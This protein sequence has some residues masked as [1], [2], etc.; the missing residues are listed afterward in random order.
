MG[1]VLRTVLVA[2]LV[3][4]VACSSGGG[5]KSMASRTASNS[6]AGS[7]SRDTSAVRLRPDVLSRAESA[8]EDVQDDISAGD[9]AA[10]LVRVDTLR[11]L[12]SRLATLRSAPGNIGTYASALDSLRSAVSRRSTDAALN[13]A[14]RISRAVTGMMAGYSAT[15]PIAVAYMDVAGRDA[16]YGATQGRWSEADSAAGEL[17]QRY[18]T[19]QAHV[20]RADTALDRRVSGEIRQLRDAIRARNAGPARALAT[21]LLKD[22]DEIEKTY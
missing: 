2:G 16:L 17:H 5:G 18:S 12:Q 10:A 6:Q 4:P 3:V 22:V 8:S 13:A 21:S 11:S 19:V 20:Q 7:T 14:N 9:W 1:R 15:V